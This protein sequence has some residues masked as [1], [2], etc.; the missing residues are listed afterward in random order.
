MPAEEALWGL[1][2]GGRKLEQYV[3]DFLELANQLSC[4]DAALG[5]CFQLGL[6]DDLLVCFIRFLSPEPL[7]AACSKAPARSRPPAAA[8]RLGPPASHMASHQYIKDIMDL[9]LP[10]RF[11][12]PI[13]SPSP[14]SQLVPSSPPMS[15]LVPSSPPERRPEPALPERPP[16]PALPERPPEPTLP[17]HLSEPAPPELPPVLSRACST[18]RHGLPN[19]VPHQDSLICH[20]HPDCVLRHGS[21]SSLICHGLPD[22]VLRHGSPSSLTRHGFLSS[23]IRPGVLTP[24]CPVSALHE[25]PGHSS[26]CPP[27]RRPEPA[28]PERPPEPAL[29]ERPPEPTLPEHL[30]E[31]APPELPLHEPPGHSSPWYICYGARRTFREGGVMSHSC[32]MFCWFRPFVPLYGLP[33]SVSC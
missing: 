33:C 2:Q 20:G 3:E 24:L 15:P 22:C 7:A 16:E 12:A 23:L 26:P 17:E 18:L 32:G 8:S 13:L 29:P 21:P 9:A 31:P 6:D 4:H 27:E 25:P 1:Q 28:L 30:S 5:A 19:C 14:T 10:M 11:D